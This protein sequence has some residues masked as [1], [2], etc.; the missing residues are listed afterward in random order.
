MLASMV[1]TQPVQPRIQI[2]PGNGSGGDVILVCSFH[3]HTPASSPQ[4]YSCA[5]VYFLLDWVS[6]GRGGGVFIKAWQIFAGII[7]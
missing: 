1:N 4:T 5:G 2:G 6:A 7:R 3:C